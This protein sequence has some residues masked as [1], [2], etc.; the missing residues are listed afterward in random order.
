MLNSFVLDYY[1]IFILAAKWFNIRCSY[2]GSFYCRNRPCRFLVVKCVIIYPTMLPNTL[3]NSLDFLRIQNNVMLINLPMVVSDKLICKM[4]SRSANDVCGYM[5]CI[6]S[7]HWIVHPS[8]VPFSLLHCA[9]L[10]IYFFGIK[11]TLLQKHAHL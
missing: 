6:L 2:D 4:S 11:I 10:R 1:Y 3:H 9:A 5:Q 8:A 7:C